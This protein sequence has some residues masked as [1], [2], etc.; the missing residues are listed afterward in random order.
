VLRSGFRQLKN[1]VAQGQYEFPKGLFF[2]GL[3][4]T[5]SQRI[6]DS[7]LGAWLGAAQRVLHLDMHTGV[8]KSGSYALCIDLPETHDR[9]TELKREF[10]AAQVQGFSPNGVLYEIRGALGPWLE[11]RTAGVRYDCLLAE[12]GTYPG[13]F[14]LAALRFD[15]RVR[16]YAGGDAELVRAAKDRML[17]AFCPRAPAWRRLVIERALRVISQSVRALAAFRTQ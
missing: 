10:G 9:V 12:F 13:L 1:A 3:E 11:Q 2:G 15:N 16:H 17:E 5:Q 6:L 8:G 14:V 4:A 7:E